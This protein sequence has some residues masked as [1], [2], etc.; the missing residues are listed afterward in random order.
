MLPLRRYHRNSPTLTWLPTG[1]LGQGCRTPGH[2]APPTQS[3][4]A[5]AYR[6]PAGSNGCWQ[7][8]ELLVPAS[9]AQAA[10]PTF[11]PD[12]A[13]RASSSRNIMSSGVA[14]SGDQPSF[15]SALWQP[16]HRWEALSGVLRCLR[17]LRCRHPASPPT[18]S[19]ASRGAL[20]PRELHR[21][22]GRHRRG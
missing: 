22:G 1:C 17:S 3:A 21:Q 10:R 16:C 18:G 7:C 6:R 19:G 15:M 5:P 13:R 8:R 20:G 14:C 9:P 11:S 2:Y 4:R 12:A